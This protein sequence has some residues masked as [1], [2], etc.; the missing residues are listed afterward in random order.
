M[1]LAIIDQLAQDSNSDNSTSKSSLQSENPTAAASH[2]LVGPTAAELESL[3]ELIKFDHVYYKDGSNRTVKSQ[4]KGPVTAVTA[5]ARPCQPVLTAKPQKQ[6]SLLPKIVPNNVAAGAVASSPSSPAV[7]VQEPTVVASE[8]QVGTLFHIP[9]SL[10]EVDNSLQQL[11][12]IDALLEQDDLHLGLAQGQADSSVT[13][14]VTP[15][16]NVANATCTG[17]PQENFTSKDRLSPLPATP[18]KRKLSS[19]DIQIKSTQ[20]NYFLASPENFFDAEYEL[21]LSTSRSESGYSSETGSVGSPQ[22]SVSS[23]L[24]DDTWQESFTE[25]FPTLL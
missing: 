7:G 18:R 22:S 1:L 8:Q 10:M 20:D 19:T 3:N 25:L 12:D 2:C 15:G 13:G 6:V 9:D 5:S 11:I 17:Q 24:G 14:A 4:T 23:P 21:N 16:T